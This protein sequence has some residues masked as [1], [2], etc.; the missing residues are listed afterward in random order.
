VQ[1]AAQARDDLFELWLHVHGLFK[2]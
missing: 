2:G 1:H